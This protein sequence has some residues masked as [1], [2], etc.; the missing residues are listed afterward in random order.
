M[1]GKSSTQKATAFSFSPITIRR[2][3]DCGSAM[4]NSSC[5]SNTG[6]MLPRTLVVT[7]QFDLLRDEGEAFARALEAAGTP[8]TLH[9]EQGALHGFVGSPARLRRIYAMGADALRDA[10]HR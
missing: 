5:K 1:R 7:A 3:G 2:R 4:S 6:I 8:V 9:R 10:L